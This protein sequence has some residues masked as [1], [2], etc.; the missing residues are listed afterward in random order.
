LCALEDEVERCFVAGLAERAVAPVLESDLVE[1]P[2]N[3]LKS[4]GDGQIDGGVMGWLATG[5]LFAY[6]SV[7]ISAS[8]LSA[9][10]GLLAT[11]AMAADEKRRA[12]NAVRG[13]GGHIVADIRP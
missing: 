12:A 3:I 8:T 13:S 4:G 2:E 10:R 5:L 1:V 6:S 9:V 11:R 7:L